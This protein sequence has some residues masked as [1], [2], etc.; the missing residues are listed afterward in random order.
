MRAGRDA[1]PVGAARGTAAGRG[2]AGAP[3]ATTLHG[4]T[5]VRGP[6]IRYVRAAVLFALA[7]VLGP[8][9]AGC[10]I[11]NT[12]VPVDAGPAP[13]RSGCAAPVRT[14]GTETG[15]PLVQRTVYLV[16]GMQVAPVKRLMPVRSDARAL[17]A[18]LQAGPLPVETAAGFLS[19]VPGS[20]GLAPV[21]K[22][23]PPGTLRLNASLDDLPS[24]ALA[25]IVCTLTD[26]SPSAPARPVV[27][28]G[29]SPSAPRSYTCT[30]DLRSRPD[31]AA[32]AGKA[33][34]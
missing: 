27:L 26:P 21:G 29:P 16:C 33:V 17:L 22:D 2:A 6:R 31:A 32:T 24:F 28:A 25:Q 11:R 14:P 8:A 1:R 10:G 12:S 23:D 5:A 34:G 18:Q 30:S 3:G 4:T 7:A 15:R 19:A 13:S 20:L 9:L